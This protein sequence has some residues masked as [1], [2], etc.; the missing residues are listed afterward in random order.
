[1]P[2]P[3]GH[4]D[5][6]PCFC[7]PQSFGDWVTW[8]H[9][10]V[11]HSGFLWLAAWTCGCPHLSGT[12]GWLR[13]DPRGLFSVPRGQSGAARRRVLQGLGQSRHGM[14]GGSSSPPLPRLVS[15]WT[16]ARWVGCRV[17]SMMV[18]VLVLKTFSHSP[19]NGCWWISATCHTVS[20]ILCNKY[21]F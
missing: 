12:S 16:T 17:L 7:V 13:Q 1:M 14:G 5:H 8:T 18:D 21:F 10:L 15:A 2:L 19:W 9:L 4:G 6:S 11:G 20:S 3:L